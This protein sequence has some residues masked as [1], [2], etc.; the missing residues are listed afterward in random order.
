M[1]QNVR[2]T[3]SFNPT[4][5]NY[6]VGLSQDF[7]NGSIASFLAPD[8]VV[9]GGTGQ[10]K[11]WGPGNQFAAVD[12]NRAIGGKPN[13]LA[14]ESSDETFNCKP[15]ALEITVDDSERDAAGEIPGAQQA[16]DEGKVSTLLATAQLA[17]EQRVIT[18]ADTLDNT[19][20]TLGSD[21]PI[22]QIDAEIKRIANAIGKMPNRLA[23]GLDLWVALRSA[24]KVLSRFPGAAQVGVTYAQF[25]S[26]LVNPAIEV[27]VST[28][29]YNTA[30]RGNT[31][32][33][34]N[35]VGNKLYLAYVDANPNTFDASAMKTFT[36]RRGGVTSVR[37]YRDEPNLDV[38]LVDWSEHVVLTN[39]EAGRKMTYTP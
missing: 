29:A 24:A 15:H 39:S 10:Y 16:L 27:K 23:I 9:P 18:I 3:A 13:R 21:D 28:I 26:L 1:A 12:T 20:L 2:G 22:A 7:R 8:V 33:N 6:A 31:K 32:S 36:G 37:T 34:S 4:L 25:A 5:T 14:F 30:K 19:A 35:T 11:K 38:H 17:Y